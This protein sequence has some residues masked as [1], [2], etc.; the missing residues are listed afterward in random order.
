MHEGS[1]KENDVACGALTPMSENDAEDF[2]QPES[3][4]VSK[5]YLT[6]KQVADFFSFESSPVLSKKDDKSNIRKPFQSKKIDETILITDS[7]TDG[8]ETDDDK[9]ALHSRLEWFHSENIVETIVI[10]SDEE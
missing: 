7:D 9:G 4:K 3:N 6:E 10:S 8:N 1:E 2:E 5:K